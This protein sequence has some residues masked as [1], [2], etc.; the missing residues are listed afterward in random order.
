MIKKLIKEKMPVVNKYQVIPL[1]FTN[2]WRNKF[3]VY[4]FAAVRFINNFK[5]YFHWVQAQMWV[6]A[7]AVTL[8]IVMWITII[9]L[10]PGWQMFSKLKVYTLS[11]SVIQ[12]GRVYSKETW[13]WVFKDIQDL[14]CFLLG[15]L[16]LQWIY[17]G[18][19]CIFN[20]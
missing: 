14:W 2:G 6:K 17:Q 16:S 15:F 5:Y 1:S 13:A 19:K 18:S 20:L 8:L 4:H 7:D 12:R 11:H 3:K 10:K 9:V